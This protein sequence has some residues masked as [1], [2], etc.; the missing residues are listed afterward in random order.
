MRACCKAWTEVLELSE[1]MET[2]SANR[3][4]NAY[5]AADGCDQCD[6]ANGPGGN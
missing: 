6:I 5:Q 2:A 4:R 3:V 1:G